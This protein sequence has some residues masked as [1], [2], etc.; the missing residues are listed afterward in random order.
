MKKLLLCLLGS[1]SPL[2]AGDSMPDGLVIIQKPIIFDEMRK[3]LTLQ[4]MQQ[5]YGMVQDE[6][7]IDPKM[8]VVHWTVIPTFEQTF[9]AF[10]PPELPAARDG[11]RAGGNLNVSSQFVIDRDGTVYQLMPETTMARHTIGINYTAI[12]IENIADGN[13]LPMTEAQLAANTKLITYLA[14]KYPIKYVLGHSEYHR[15]RDT[16]WWKE[17]DANYFTEKNDPDIAFMQRLR[18][19]LS[20]LSLKPLP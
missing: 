7:V 12:G 10:N 2:Y 19:S 17:T 9:A 16:D 5:H 11:I 1:I 14:G 15:F 3:A 13:S 6:P 8:V 18:S 4:Y 20:A